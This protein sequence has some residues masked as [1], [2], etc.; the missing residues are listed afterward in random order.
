MI[1]KKIILPTKRYAKSPEEELFTRIDLT[2]EQNI[3]R[4]NDKNISIDVAELYNKERN[5]SNRYNIYG[6]IRVV[7]DNQYYGTVEYEYLKNN[8]YLLGFGQVG[9]NLG[10]LPYNEFAFLRNDLL[11]QYNTHESGDEL[12]NF[13]PNI[14]VTEDFSQHTKI[15]PISAPYQNWNV[16]LSYVYTGLTNQQLT[17]TLS[18]DTSYTFTSSDGIPFI[19]SSDDTYYI[20]T[21]PVEHGMNQG[22]YVILSGGTFTNAVEEKNRIFKIQSVGD[23]KYR[24]DKFVINILKTE[25]KVTTPFNN[26]NVVLGKRCINNKDINNTKSTYYVHKH[27][28]LTN[29]NDYLLD[30]LGFESS[31]WEDEKKLLYENAAGVN[32][33]LVEKNRMENVLY[34]FKK[35]FILS[36]LT[37]NLGYTPTEVYTTIVFRNG[38]GYFDYPPK[39]GYSFNFHDTWIDNHFDGNDSLETNLTYSTFT[40]TQN[41][42]SF[43]FKSGITLN[44]SDELIGAYVE[45]NPMELKERIISDAYHKIVHPINIFDH[46]QDDPNEFSGSSVTNTFG[47]YYKPHNKVKLRELSPYV[48][49]SNTKDIINLPENAKYYENEKLWKWRDLY[50]HGFIDTEGFGTDFPF[51]NG[52]HYILN[53][54]NFYIKNEKNYTNKKDEIKDFDKIDC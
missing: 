53:N 50:D 33:F 41:N 2:Q 36:G 38:N 44:I 5:L 15:T 28:I 11:R 48:E 43:Q 3:L 40:R 52:M 51:I 14:N 54:I 34:S 37:N 42:T 22:E 16:Y 10:Y 30:K 32:D 31:I 27:K 45:Y 47:I 4:E 46:N 25:F 19:V 9:D 8:L 23:E 1:S 18:G 35:P 17:Y 26:G 21:S 29:S 6:K 39:V 49:I 13:T 24:S 20:L 12:I 7:F